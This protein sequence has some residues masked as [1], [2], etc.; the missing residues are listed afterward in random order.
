MEVY[1]FV[2][3]NL[4]QVNTCLMYKVKFKRE[5]ELTDHF[6]RPEIK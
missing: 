4:F 2:V 6:N 1:N 5:S 3:A